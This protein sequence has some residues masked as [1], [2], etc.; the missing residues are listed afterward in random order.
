MA[1]DSELTLAVIEEM[2]AR[3]GAGTI[4][5]RNAHEMVELASRHVVDLILMDCDL[6]AMDGHDA[7]RLLRQREATVGLP[8]DGFSAPLPAGAARLPIIATAANVTSVDRGPASSID[9][10]LAKPF[11]LAELRQCME[12]WLPAFD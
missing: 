1:N 8:G 5:A 2:L 3:L 6:P 10:C 11:G 4:A 9:D 7:T 12:L